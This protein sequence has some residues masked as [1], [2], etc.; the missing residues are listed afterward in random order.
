MRSRE[1]RHSAFDATQSATRARLPHGTGAAAAAPATAS[2]RA[3]RGPRPWRRAA[4]RAPSRR[5]P[6]RAGAHRAPP[7]SRRGAARRR[8]DGTCCTIS[9]PARQ[10]HCCAP[11]ASRPMK[12]RATASRMNVGSCSDWRKYVCAASVS[13]P[14]SSATMPWWL[15]CSPP[16]SMVMASRPLPSSTPLILRR[17]VAAASA[18]RSKLA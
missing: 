9:P 13:V 12:W 11:V 2:G 7:A 8:R 17:R 10:R 5:P 14:P 15:T 18:D 4:A 16:G 3:A 1:Q 6:R